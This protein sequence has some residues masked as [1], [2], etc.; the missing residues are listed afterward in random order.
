MPDRQRCLCQAVS[1]LPENQT[2]R[3]EPPSCAVRAGDQQLR[4]KYCSLV[5]LD[6]A[7]AEICSVN[8]REVSI[9][10]AFQDAARVERSGC[11]ELE[12][13]PVSLRRAVPHSR[14]A[15]GSTS[16]LPAPSR[17]R[18]LKRKRPVVQSNRLVA[19]SRLIYRIAASET[20]SPGARALL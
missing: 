8:L 14:H 13:R 20:S 7:F 19:G 5:I 2:P 3:H 10:C 16:I 12:E 6:R 11:V 9:R 18:E 4:F 1:L 17:R 15:V